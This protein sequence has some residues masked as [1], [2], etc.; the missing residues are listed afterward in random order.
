MKYDDTFSGTSSTAD[1][2]VIEAQ[3]TVANRLQEAGLSTK[4]FIEL[5]EGGKGSRQNHRQAKNHHEPGEIRGNYGVYGGHG[6]LILDIDDYR[7]GASVAPSIQNLPPTFTVQSPHS[8]KH[9]Y[10]ATDSNIADTLYAQFGARNPQ[11]TCGEI[12]VHNQY[13]V[14]PGSELS[15]CDKTGH[16]CSDPGEGRYWIQENREIAFLNTDELISA[17]EQ[18]PNFTRR[19]ATKEKPKVKQRS[20]SGIGNIHSELFRYRKLDTRLDELWLWACRSKDPRE[21]G[22]PNDRSGAETALSAKLWYW[23]GSSEKVE[24]AFKIANPPKW[25]KSGDSYKR[26]IIATGDNGSYHQSIPSSGGGGVLHETMITIVDALHRT[27][28][29]ARTKELIE[30]DLIKVSERQVQ[31]ALKLLKEEGYVDDERRGL[32]SYWIYDENEIL[33]VH[34]QKFI[35]NLTTADEWAAQKKRFLNHE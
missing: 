11:P 2:T 10:F 31:N 1:V 9:W 21:V 27:G 6:L 26:S 32:Y 5:Y 30:D 14:G 7:S 33:G 16:D 29:K 23:L 34:G 17:L 28:G 3:R 4:R 22:F 18:D 25:S 35:D 24:A 8:G 15:K 20:E 13:C 19:N 12:R